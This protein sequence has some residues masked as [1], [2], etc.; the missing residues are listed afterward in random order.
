MATEEQSAP[1]SG[2]PAPGQESAGQGPAG[3]GFSVRC[4][5]PGRPVTAA[6]RQE[7]LRKALERLD[8]HAA[9]DRKRGLAQ[10]R[11]Y[12][13]AGK[14]P[15]HA[16][17]AGYMEEIYAEAR[18]PVLDPPKLEDY[19]ED[20]LAGQTV[21]ARVG[22]PEHLGASA[23]LDDFAA[24][25]R[26]ETWASWPPSGPF[27]ENWGPAEDLA[28]LPAELF[29]ET[30]GEYYAERLRRITEGT[31][32]DWFALFEATANSS[33]P[34]TNASDAG[35]AA[36]AND[37]ADTGDASSTNDAADAEAATAI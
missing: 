30:H 28:G 7:A 27:P 2:S 24:W 12:I 33:N 20:P 9:Q 3:Q 1:V 25:E 4:L 36:D 21:P 35:D 15:K 31:P 22:E 10:A 34:G 23:G 13:A 11:E 16:T 18:G 5:Q 37:A 14:P 17:M 26:E 8:L 29:S 6:Q 19:G 32:A